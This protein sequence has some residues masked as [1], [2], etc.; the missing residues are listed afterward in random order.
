MAINGLELFLPVLAYKLGGEVRLRHV[1]RSNTMIGHKI[2]I[3]AHPQVQSIVRRQFLRKV[4]HA[5]LRNHQH[6]HKVLPVEATKEKGDCGTRGTRPFLRWATSQDAVLVNATRHAVRSD[7][8]ASFGLALMAGEDSNASGICG[9]PY[10]GCD[11]EPRTKTL[12]RPPH[13][14]DLV[15][16]G[17]HHIFLDGAWL[18]APGGRGGGRGGGHA[19]AAAVAGLATYVCLCRGDR[20]ETKETSRR[21]PQRT[22]RAHRSLVVGHAV[23]RHRGTWPTRDP[24][25]ASPKP[26]FT[27]PPQLARL[28]GKC[29]QEEASNH[30]PKYCDGW[31]PINCAS[32]TARTRPVSSYTFRVSSVP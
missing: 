25:H 17:L 27:S 7:V 18:R 13:G 28:Q 31:P 11:V 19:A 6:Q 3:H 4:R 26:R 21:A 2:R 5:A 32:T 10:S 9:M 14:A 12:R 24:C 16:E 30:S 22:E 8:D 23:L 29:D 1:L 20:G 15:D